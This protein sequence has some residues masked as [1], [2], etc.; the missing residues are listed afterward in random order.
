[1]T[2]EPGNKREGRGEG[3]GLCI[4]NKESTT[5]KKSK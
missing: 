4:Q 3:E 5:Q 2:G 1:M